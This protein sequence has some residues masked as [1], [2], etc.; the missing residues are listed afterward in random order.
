MGQRTIILAVVGSLAALLIPLLAYHQVRFSPKL[1]TIEQT[2]ADY[3]PS[4]LTTPRKT[5]QSVALTT[6]VTIPPSAASTTP[7]SGAAPVA[8]Q[9]FPA[10]VAAAAVPTVSFILQDSGKDMAIINGNV[11]KTGDRY[12]EWRVERIERAR[13]LLIGRKGPLWIALQ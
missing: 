1:K 10:A 11:L 2:M 7:L 3:K 6:P 12:R 8:L 5:W 4:P 9:P 13:V